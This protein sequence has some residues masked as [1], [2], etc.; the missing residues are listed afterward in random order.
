MAEHLTRNEKVVGS[1]PTISSK[2]SWISTDIQDFLYFYCAFVF[3]GMSG[4]LPFPAFQRLTASGK[5]HTVTHT[6]KETESTRENGIVV[7]SVLLH[8]LT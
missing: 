5:T 8:V 2:K 4:G 7:S 1:I 6:P 3:H